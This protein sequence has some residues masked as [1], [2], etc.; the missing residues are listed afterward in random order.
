MSAGA[1]KI[2]GFAMA[3]APLLSAGC[4]CHA[5][6]N[7]FTAIGI[8]EL[9]VGLS[10]SRTGMTDVAPSGYSSTYQRYQFDRRRL[11]RQKTEQQAAL[12]ALTEAERESGKGTEAP[13]KLAQ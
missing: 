6:S 5:G 11:A 8:R 13:L 12:K 4:L 1:R 10:G 3:L 2:F 7:V 9:P